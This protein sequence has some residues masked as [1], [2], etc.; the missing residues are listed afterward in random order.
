M[1]YEEMK[2]LQRNNPP[3][4]MYGCMKSASSKHIYVQPLPQ[5]LM[6]HS[7]QEPADT[8]FNGLSLSD[9]EGARKF[10]G[11]DALHKAD[12]VAAELHRSEQL[13]SELKEVGA[14]N[15]ITNRSK[16]K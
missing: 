12:A 11:M 1:T 6:A 10:K 4:V 15:F 5:D 9:V 3:F 2:K 14:S 7:K 13:T 16:R 8:K